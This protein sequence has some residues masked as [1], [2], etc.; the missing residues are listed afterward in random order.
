MRRDEY[1]FSKDASSFHKV[2]SVRSRLE[3][4][5]LLVQRLHCEAGDLL[6]KRLGR[7]KNHNQGGCPSVGRNGRN[8]LSC[9]ESV[10]TKIVHKRC[11]CMCLSGSSSLDHSWSTS[12]QM[13]HT[14]NTF[15]RLLESSP[16]A[17]Q[18]ICHGS[19]G[20]GQDWRH[21][22]RRQSPRTRRYRSPKESAAD[23]IQI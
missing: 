22:H 8:S 6:T 14:R 20:H 19:G 15:L 21:M 3:D 5:W 18:L 4:E 10:S 9:L 17:C 16:A 2:S 7:R 13:Q 23:C 1:N 12:A 11:C